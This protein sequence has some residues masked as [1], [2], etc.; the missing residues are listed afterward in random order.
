MN[1]ATSEPKPKLLN[2]KL[3]RLMKQLAVT[4]AEVSKWANINVCSLQDCLN[5]DNLRASDYCYI[6]DK[7]LSLALYQSRCTNVDRLI[8][9]NDGIKCG[10]GTKYHNRTVSVSLQA[11]NYGDG[12]RW[13]GQ[14][15]NY[16]EGTREWD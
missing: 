3:Q 7:M 4:L 15:N 8:S 13:T 11:T 2:K 9:L 6:R 10:N 16:Y 12:K 1:T 5:N 14:Y